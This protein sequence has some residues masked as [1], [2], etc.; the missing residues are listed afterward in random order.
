MSKS[1]AS[2]GRSVKMAK[3]GGPGLIY[4]IYIQGAL[5]GNLLQYRCVIEIDFVQLIQN[6][7]SVAKAHRD[8]LF[9]TRLS[10][11]SPLSNKLVRQTKTPI[12]ARRAHSIPR[13]VVTVQTRLDITRAKGFQFELDLLQEYQ[14]L[15][16]YL[17]TAKGV[18]STQ[19]PILMTAL[20]KFPIIS[21]TLLANEANISKHTAKRWLVGLEKN[22]KLT[23]RDFNGMKQ[24]AYPAVMEILDRII[25]Y[26]AIP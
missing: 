24:Y 8:R 26:S 3:K 21:I 7:L 12:Y 20:S 19:I 13:P 15:Y 23:T 25:R 4:R 17:L 14:F 16:H 9:R 2:G 10:I 11:E 22:G 1:L 5:L 6:S 18:P